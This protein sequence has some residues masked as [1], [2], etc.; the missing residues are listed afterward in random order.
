MVAGIQDLLTISRLILKCDVHASRSRINFILLIIVS[1]AFE[2]SSIAI[3][4]VISRFY[5]SVTSRDFELFL[6]CLWRSLIV[7]SVV[8]AMKSLKTYFT[9]VCALEWRASLVKFLHENCINKAMVAYNA[10]TINRLENMD[11]RITQDLYR[12]TADAAK[13][14]ADVATAPAVIIFYS[15]YLWRKVGFIPPVACFVYFLLGSLCTYLQARKLIPRVYLQEMCEGRFRLLHSQFISNIEAIALLGGEHSEWKRMSKSFGHLVEIVRDVIN[16]QLPLYL[17]V[18]WF[19]YFGAIVNYA[20]VGASVL[21][22]MRKDSIEHGDGDDS[23]SSSDTASL[24]AEGSYACLYLI[25]GFSTLLEA[26]QTTSRVLALC[27]RVCE[28]ARSCEVTDASVRAISC[29]FDALCICP[30]RKPRASGAQRNIFVKYENHRPLTH[31]PSKVATFTEGNGGVCEAV[32]RAVFGRRSSRPVSGD[33]SRCSYMSL[34]GSDDLQQELV[35]D[36]R[37]SKKSNSV[38]TMHLFPPSGTMD[39]GVQLS[40]LSNAH[41]EHTGAQG[42]NT[43][44]LQTLLEVD[45][46]SLVLPSFDGSM[47]RTLF[48]PV[49][50]TV[51]EGEHTASV[52]VAYCI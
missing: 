19:S 35:L 12:L 23:L 46:F 10:I 15:Y 9:E 31:V 39:S 5:F 8:S 7:I 21:Y 22:V 1:F 13:L 32:E 51:H 48:G 25:S 47:A 6:T 18:N 4:K 36:T 28:L 49:S 26:S 11:Q 40:A 16:T 43:H 24:L 30:S 34:A 41:S 3:M 17:I 52:I 33:N 38:P 2:I 14:V 20:V 29:E 45:Q 44:H 27:T 37:S 42:T 50:F